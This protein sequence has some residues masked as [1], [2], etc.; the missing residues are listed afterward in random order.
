MTKNVVSG[1]RLARFGFLFIALAM[2]F[3]VVHC[4]WAAS[5]VRV[6]PVFD[7]YYQLFVQ[8]T[9]LG[10]FSEA[11][12]MGS[13]TELV[14]QKIVGQPG[15]NH[16]LKVPGATRIL[17]VTLKRSL[18]SNL[19]V[20]NWRKAVQDGDIAKARKDVVI[21][22]FDKAG[23]AIAIWNLKAAWPCKLID[24]PIE[25]A[26]VTGSANNPGIEAVTLTA[27]DIIRVK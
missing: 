5:P 16:L 9:S 7:G 17:N 27:E 20:A 25:G 22:M 3:G 26:P 2:V 24:N 19:E 18:T 21:T 13:E 23:V 15:K 10:Y 1:I 4:V 12:N 11:Y 6:D 14:D 8:G